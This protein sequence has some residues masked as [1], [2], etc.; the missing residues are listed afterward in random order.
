M[1]TTHIMHDFYP[2]VFTYLQKIQIK[3]YTRAPV[4]LC[5]RACVYGGGGTCTC[6][7]GGG[8]TCMRVC[9]RRCILIISIC[10]QSFN[11]VKRMLPPPPTPPHTHARARAHT[12]TC[13][14]AHT[15]TRAH[16]H[17]RARADSLICVHA[18]ITYLHACEIVLIFRS[19]CIFWVN[20]HGCA[21][22]CVNT[23]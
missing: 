21:C 20:A 7:Y 11:I 8:G 19:F 9:K 23:A 6:V 12:H 17:A 13:K 18:H 22:V 15:R 1:A 3:V 10:T 5:V 16:T 2:H 4:C 14:Q